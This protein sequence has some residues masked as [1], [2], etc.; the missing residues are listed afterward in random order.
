M[1]NIKLFSVI[2]ASAALAM[3]SCTMEIDN[4]ADNTQVEQ[5]KKGG[6]KVT[7]VTDS[8]ATKTALEPDG[9]TVSWNSDDEVGFINGEDGVNVESSHALLEGTQATFSGM[10][11]TAGTYY[12]YYPYSG[13][14][15]SSY[16]AS[17]AGVTVRISNNQ[18]PT[19]PDTFDPKAD[20]LLSTPF[21]ATYDDEFVETDPEAIQ[22]KRVG[23][24]LKVYFADATTG[25]KLDGESAS[26]VAVESSAEKLVG[27]FRL[28]GE[29]GLVFQNSGYFKVTASYDPGTFVIAANEAYLGI[30]PVTLPGESTLTITSETTHYTISKTVTLPKDIV[31][32]AG[33]IQPLRI[34]VADANIT[35]KAPQVEKVWEMLSTN[36]SSW[37]TNLSAGGKTGGAGTDFNIAVDDN[38]VYVPEFGTS[39]VIWAISVNDKTDVKLVNTDNVTSTGYDGTVY[40][41]CARVVQK[42]DGTPVLIATNTF[43]DNNGKLYIWDNGIDNEP[44]VVTLDQWSAGRRLGDKFTTYGNYEDCWLLFGTQTGNGF[45]T[46]KL[47][48]SGTSAGLISRLAIDLT[49]FATYYPFPG[50]LTRG[51]FAWHGGSHD[52]GSLYRNRLMTVSSTESAIKDSG[53]HTSE[54]TKLTQW[55]ANSENNNGTGFNY[56]EFGGMRY[57]IWCMN[58]TDSKTFDL[59]I[60]S[61]STETDWYTIINTTG[62]V[63]RESL[64]GGLDTSW[65]KSADCAVFNNGS[66]LYVAINKQNVGIALYRIHY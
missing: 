5:V 56:T 15:D 58:S 41:S 28:S 22:F 46:F 32:G 64:V 49:D 55:M 14:D 26:F 45:V 50:E 59:I 47:P 3:V 20:L 35:P 63:F 8:P 29:G 6:I 1:K 52:D 37:T 51:M 25:G 2:A 19:S 10:V 9:Q 60:K 21:V 53:A 36:A 11:P 34:T 7:V 31:I 65:K 23:A 48:T 30:R 13:A 40:L 54:L 4:P 27:R 42:S 44:R 39:K 24:F 62:T 57:V 38:Y 18:T 43:S 33:S 16:P 61:G 66:E 17:D 12:A